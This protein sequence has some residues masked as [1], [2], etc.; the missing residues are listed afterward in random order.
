MNKYQQVIPQ[1]V[2]Q[3]PPSY[4]ERQFLH[5]Y[6]AGA[7]LP[8]L[9]ASITAIMAGVLTVIVCLKLRAVDILEPTLMVMA[10][11]WA[12]AWLFLQRRWLNLT[13]LERALNWDLNRDGYIGQAPAPKSETVIRLDDVKENGHFQ[14]FTY[15]FPVSEEQLIILADGV[16]NRGRPL[17]RREWTPKV[18]GFSDDEYRDLQSTMLKHGLLEPRGTG[19]DLT[20]P[21]RAMMRYYARL[22]PTASIDPA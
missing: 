16:I 3:A 5:T 10:V 2:Q 18:N 17:S 4:S 13:A 21:G 22:S 19:F 14:S 8:F 6:L 11:V 1:P 7:F 20:R 12:G 15:K 9:Q